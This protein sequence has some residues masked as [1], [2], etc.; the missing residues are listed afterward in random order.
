MENG[1]KIGQ[2]IPAEVAEQATAQPKA[3][4]TTQEVVFEQPKP[5]TPPMG[6]VPV[7]IDEATGRWVTTAGR[8]VSY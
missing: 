7:A 2:V 3:E 6:G 4:P 1:S 5:L 8:K